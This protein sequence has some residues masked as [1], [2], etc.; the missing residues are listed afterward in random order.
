[1]DTP[2]TDGQIFIGAAHF[3]DTSTNATYASAGAG[4]FTLNQA[5]SK[6]STYFSEIS[7]ILRTGMLATAA[8]N[9]EQFGTAALVPGPSGVANTSGPLALPGGFPPWTNSVNPTV[10][11][12]LPASSVGKGIEIN[13]F[14]VIY[15]IEAVNLTTA[16]C[17]L[18]KTTF[19]K[20]AAAPTVTNI[21]ALAANGLPVAYSAG[22]AQRT[23]VA[24]TT[25][26]FVTSDG[27]EILLNVNLTT[28]AGGT[29][30]FYGV[31]VGV[32]FNF[33]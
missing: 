8:L 33:N 3:K 21:V 24:V 14:D 18:T 10:S 7:E 22:V 11:G 1:M 26:A 2:N 27:T 6:A 25:P 28:P 29:S 12:N 15:D 31:V 17:G 32:S 20:T 30:L 4:L 19:S 16:T 9:Q 13:W 23:R 5:A